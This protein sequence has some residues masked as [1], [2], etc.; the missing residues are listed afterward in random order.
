MASQR[1]VAVLGIGRMGGAM[2]STISRAGHPV[3]LWN[4]RRD[5]AE[6]VATDLGSPVFGSPAEAVAA[7]EVVITSL[8]DDAAVRE[9]YLGNRGVVAGVR[10]G[11]VVMDTSTVSP[12]TVIEVGA[13]VEEAGGKFLDCPVSGSVSVVEAGNLTIMAGGDP[14]VLEEARPILEAMSSRIVHT[15]Q[16]GT[17]A[18]TKLAVNALVHGLNIALSE[19]LVLAERAGVDRRVAYEV[20]ANGAGGAPFVQYKR[21]AYEN[22]DETP[23]AFSLDLVQKDLELITGLAKSVG[24]PMTQAAAGLDLVRAANE[25][26][27]ADKD[28]SALAEYMRG[29]AG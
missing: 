25:A 2:A 22:P 12:E 23:V 17:G 5:K 24:A 28:L 13:A 15:G 8:A 19:A 20:F 10:P 6:R 27:F 7:A 4:R 14:E 16:R 21:E 29:E 9:V 3:V 11:T 1:T 18:A 26:G